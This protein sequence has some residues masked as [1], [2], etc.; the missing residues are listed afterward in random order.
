MINFKMKKN[1]IAAA[2]STVLTSTAFAATPSLPAKQGLSNFDLNAQLA[3]AVN[4]GKHKAASV[5]KS[6]HKTSSIQQVAIGQKNGQKKFTLNGASIQSAARGDQFDKALN[7]TTFSWAQDSKKNAAQPLGVL[8]PKAAIAAANLGYV[9]QMGAKHGVSAAA[10]AQAELKYV[11]DNQ[12]SAII[13][14]YQQKANG[15]DVYGRQFNVLMNQRMELIATT[16]YFSNAKAD[17]N[18]KGQFILS[19][20]QAIS[21]AFSDIGGD[22]ISLSRDENKDDYQAFKANSNNYSF[23]SAPRGKK[24]Y[25]P[26]K[27][28]LIPAWYVEIMASKADST[29][30]IAYSHVISAVDGSVLNRTNMV[31]RDA[32]SYKM[33]ADGSAP[34]TP[35][36]SPMGNSL[37]P[38]PTGV[39]NDVIAQTQV[40]MNDITLE[41]AGISTNDPW[42]PSGASTTSGNNV[43]AYAD[44]VAPDGFSEGDVRAVTTSANIF[45]YPYDASD[46][47]DSEENINAAVVNLFYTN[48]YLH[49]VY[50]DHGFD[51]AAGIA[52]QD[53]FGRGGVDGDPLHVEAQDVGGLNNANMATPADGASP[54]MQM[55]LWQN[56]TI[57]DGTVDNAIVAHEWGHYISSRLT[58]G[59]MYSN[60]QGGSMGEGWGDFF[61]LMMMVRE[62]DQLLPGN[63]QW[64]AAYNDG[65]YAV[66]NGFVEFAYFFGLRRFPYSTDMAHNALTFK[67][68]EDQVALPTTHPI[69]NLYT[70]DFN[71]DGVLNSEVHN[72]GEL[73]ALMLWE[74]YAA[75]LNRDDLSFSEA[76][77][78][79]MDYMVASMKITP[80]APTYTEARDALLA[81]AIANDI[82]DHNLFRQ[83]F[84]KRGMGFNAVSPARFDAGFDGTFDS[85]GH[86]GVVESFDVFGSGVSLQS[87]S[88]DLDS[89]S[90]HTL[91]CDADGVLDAGETSTLTI[92]INNQGTEVLSGIKA[93]LSSEADITFANDGLIEFADISQWR[94]S[95]AATVALT[96]NSAEI[97]ESIDITV[98]LIS[99]DASMVLPEAVTT[100]LSVNFD[101]AHTRAIEDF[102]NP[103]SVWK[104][105]QRTKLIARGEDPEH[106]LSQWEVFDDV[107]FGNV[108]FGPD[109]SQENDISLISPKVTV[110][111][112]GEFAMSFEHYYDFEMGDPNNPD[113]QTAW[114]GAVIEISIDGGEWTDVVAAGGSFAPDKGY[115][116]TIAA[117]NP[118][119]ANRPGFVGLIPGFWISPETLAFPEGSLNGK[120][121]QLR[122][123][124][125]SDQSVAAWGW[126]IDNLTFANIT[127]ATPFSEIVAN[128]TVCSIAPPPVPEVSALE[129]SF[130]GEVITITVS[131]SDQ[132]N[133]HFSYIWKQVSGSTPVDVSSTSATLAFAAPL[134]SDDEVYTFSV[135]STDGVLTSAKQQVSVTIIANTAPVLSTDQSNVSVKERGSLTLGVSGSDLEN[136]ALTY[137]WSING[138]RLSSTGDS[139]QLTAPS[140]F[141]D[142]TMTFSVTAFDGHKMSEITELNVNV[143]ANLPP[144]ITTAQASV[145]VNEG[146]P[147]TL[148]VSGSD[149]ENDSLTYQWIQDGEVTNNTGPTFNF[150]S[151]SLYVD[152][153]VSFS[154]TASDGD[155]TS[156]AVQIN[157]KV[158]NRS[159]GGSMGLLG[160]LLA[161]L[162][163]IR[164][165]KRMH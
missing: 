53:N 69:S 139:H 47:V 63:D 153:S 71:M 98:T 78:R 125:G 144:V 140:V 45:D 86:A 38:H 81:V 130:E 57:R 4:N 61:A 50:Y 103:V 24:V 137:Q 19:A 151:D 25:Y 160:F 14:K 41:H 105:W 51:E 43:D 149:P 115:T 128:A 28:K 108:M 27:K 29:T 132:E 93:Q 107:D 76:Q 113:D 22:E 112:S 74:S 124:I 65:G 37:T 91:M 148:Q 110:A 2:I 75:L 62:S 162:A 95:T 32:F 79:M 40:S 48:N 16:G 35:F 150:T 123:R 12:K 39:Y 127:N 52:Q 87:L 121:V 10:F 100:T 120:E 64:Q 161:P 122:F 119:L 7:T 83:A 134:V 18:V 72:A 99:D 157:L 31:Q 156:E 46:R 94:D 58:N 17:K 154:V 60:N 77:S 20:S 33:F 145:S 163:F 106:F 97:D 15:I 66:A 158:N 21:N 54:R 84:A 1:L 49:D 92:T 55:F 141:Q 80:F 70:A 56:D 9:K 146:Q 152:A 34:Y 116:G 131:N 13:S 5:H 89:S 117:F 136:D 26:G 114:D 90:N 109:L 42:L 133:S 129:S 102:E 67:H 85:Q 165:R 142:T 159:G 82:D 6:I 30:L 73:W 3:N 164:R 104:D 143:I 135:A 11:S 8:S 155:E 101:L 44:L 68:I 138:A 147:V 118:S 59:G 88:I 23:S 36:D 96:L 111:D 126:N